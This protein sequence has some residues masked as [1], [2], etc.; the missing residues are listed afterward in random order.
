LTKQM[1]ITIINILVFLVVCFTL[2]LVYFF[3]KLSKIKD[4]LSAFKKAVENSDNVIVMTDRKSNIIFANDAFEKVSGYK[5]GEAIGLN[6]KV[7]KSGIQD[8]SFYQELNET[9][10]SGKTWKGRFINKKKSGELFYENATITPIFSGE[11]IDGYL[12]IK[13]DVTESVMHAK[14]LDELNKSL[15]KRVEESVS[16]L[17]EKDNLILNQTKMAA[18]GE[19]I[20]NIAHQWRQPLSV[21]STSASGMSLQID[22]GILNDEMAKDYCEHINQNAQYLSK[23]IDDFRNF[24]KGDSKKEE[25]NLKEVIDSFKNLI[26]SSIKK[27]GI[28]LIVDI[29]DN[30]TISNL[31]NELNQCLI[32]LFNNSKDAMVENEIEEKFVKISAFIEDEKLVI[33]FNDNGG[34]IDENIINKIFEPYFTTKHQSIGT[35][36]GLNMTYRLITEGMGGSIVVENGNI[37]YKNRSYFGARFKITL[38]IS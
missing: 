16:K 17:R 19:M 9:I 29:S 15:E 1:F 10:Y 20:G 24:I 11:K 12:A 35:G 32:N 14:E 28:N 21:I 37:E 31:R 23:T 38:P 36:L 2:V 13:L 34:G 27:Y 5:K 22:M 3:V 8:K 18:L 33:L 26:E 6:P 30:I 7:L 25:F 4:Q